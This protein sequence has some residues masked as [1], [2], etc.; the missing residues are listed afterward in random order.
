MGTPPTTN[1]KG[2][3][4]RSGMHSTVSSTA[5]WSQLETLY[6]PKDPLSILSVKRTRIEKIAFHQIRQSVQSE[7]RRLNYPTLI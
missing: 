4:M 1:L 6:G 3:K 7:S 2:S 5:N